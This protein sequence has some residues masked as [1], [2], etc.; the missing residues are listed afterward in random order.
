MPGAMSGRE[1]ADELRRSSPKLK[2]V[3]ISGYNLSVVS[4]DTGFLRRE[5]NYFVQKPFKSLL[6]VETIRRCL[7]EIKT[8]TAQK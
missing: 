4:N 5:N 6:L 8:A 1:L 3:F 2:V 7:D